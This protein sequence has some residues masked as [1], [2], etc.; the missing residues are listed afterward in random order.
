MIIYGYTLYDRKALQYNVPFFAVADGVAVRML[1]ELV[2]DTNTSPGRHPGDYVLY[3]CGAY[4]DSNGS[5]HP[6]SALRHVIDALAVAPR[7]APLPFDP[8]PGDATRAAGI[9]TPPADADEVKFNG[10]G[11]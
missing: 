7:A 8:Q 3:C 9:T 6:V 11:V 4:D 10:S 2:A 5:L 1:Q